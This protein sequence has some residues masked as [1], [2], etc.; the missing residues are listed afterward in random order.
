MPK[1]Y[2]LTRS[3]FSAKA[4]EG[5]IAFAGF[6]VLG[7]EGF[8]GYEG[9]LKIA[10]FSHSDGNGYLTLTFIHDLDSDTDRCALL[11]ARFLRLAQDTLM[12]RLGPDFEMLLDMQ[13]HPYAESSDFYIEELNLYF[14]RLAGRERTL[15]EDWVIP[16]LDHLLDF[17]F[18]RLD[19]LDQRQLD[20][21]LDVEGHVPTSLT[22]KRRLKR[23]LGVD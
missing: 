14:H 2:D 11:Q 21:V 19:W 10:A 23:W 18:E 6:Q 1:S 7:E 20:S 8:Q 16:T 5:M 17:R 4:E 13:L 15:L 9:V 12:Q 22:L 3:L